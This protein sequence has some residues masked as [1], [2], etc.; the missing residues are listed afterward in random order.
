VSGIA[1]QIG[2]SHPGI[3]KILDAATKSEPR[4]YS[5]LGGFHLVDASDT[6]VTEKVMRLRDEW[7]IERMA[8]GQFAFAEMVRIYGA[9]F[10]H[11]GVGAVIALPA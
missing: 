2:C 5:A 9:S 4:I 8:A 10:D 7:R 6:E 1:P 3:E 11:A